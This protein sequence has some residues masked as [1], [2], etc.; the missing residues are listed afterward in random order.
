MDDELLAVWA[1]LLP[2]ERGRLLCV[3]EPECVRLID[4]GM[5]MLWAAE[6]QARQFGVRGS[7]DPFDHAQLPL[8]ATM[9]FDGFMHKGE[10]VFKSVK[11]PKDFHEDPMI[12][13]NA[14][15]FSLQAS[16]GSKRRQVAPIKANRWH[17]LLAPP[18]QSW[19]GFEMQLAQLVEQLVLRAEVGSETADRP[20]QEET[21]VWSSWDA[22]KLAPAPAPEEAEEADPETS[23]QAPGSRA[24]KRQRQRERRKLGKALARGEAVDDLAA[25]AGVTMPAV[26]KGSKPLQEVQE[27]EVEPIV[28]T[29]PEVEAAAIEV[30]PRPVQNHPQEES[31]AEEAEDDFLPG[32]FVD[33][34]RGFGRGRPLGR[35][36]ENPMLGRG[37]GRGRALAPPPGLQ[38]LH[39]SGNQRMPASLSRPWMAGPPIPEDEDVT[40]TPQASWVDTQGRWVPPLDLPR[41]AWADM[42]SGSEF[43]SERKGQM[44][45]VPTPKQKWS[46]TPSPPSSPAGLMTFGLPDA[47]PM[48]IGPI[49]PAVALAASAA[50]TSAASLKDTA[51]L[52]D[53]GIPVYVTVPIAVAK[54]CPHCGKH[55]AV[56]SKEDPG[57]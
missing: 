37:M 36:S 24:A 56:P 29:A 22:H 40:N 17:Q 43:G 1:R 41:R 54:C 19:A 34:N 31:P 4:L 33:T 6:I 49:G 47:L 21:C 26:K 28:S 50:A 57:G 10:K 13:A 45:Y 39:L 9:Q 55:F 8:L 48:P 20:V 15:R 44:S 23:S 2:E 42:D 27:A 14:L 46:K 52:A 5:Q 38:G 7:T 51:A 12:L 53:F 18:A 25:A 11:W 32:L 16:M 30:A 35:F 3:Q